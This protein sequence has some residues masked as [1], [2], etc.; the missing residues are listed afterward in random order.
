MV[1]IVE[2]GVVPVALH[3]AVQVGQV[4]VVDP[5]Q[6]VLGSTIRGYEKYQLS[7]FDFKQELSTV[8]R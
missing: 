5:K 8:L 1:K 2:S 4:Q 6:F 7:Y 3:E